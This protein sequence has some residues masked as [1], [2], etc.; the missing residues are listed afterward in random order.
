MFHPALPASD[1]TARG[2]PPGTGND[3]RNE[4]PPGWTR[5]VSSIY[6][7]DASAAIDWLC[8]AFGFEVKLKVGTRAV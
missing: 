4:P 5:F 7:D 1:E 2:P 3:P 6:Y 8:D